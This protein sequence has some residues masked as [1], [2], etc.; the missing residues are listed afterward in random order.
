MSRLPYVRG[1]YDQAEGQ[2]AQPRDEE[3]QG[4][5]MYAIGK[6]AGLPDEEYREFI[7]QHGYEKT[8]DV[9]RSDYEAMVS[10]LQGMGK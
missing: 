3:A 6:S 9:K 10:E 1:L 4:K 8:G 7:K 5:R 2:A